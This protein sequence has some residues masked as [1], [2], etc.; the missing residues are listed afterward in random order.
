MENNP[1]INCFSHAWGVYDAYL[2]FTGNSDIASAA[3]DT[4]Y[5]N[6]LD[7]GGSPGSQEP[8]VIISK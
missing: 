4:A 1:E 6:C 8:V 5:E 2:Q 7:Y 3:M